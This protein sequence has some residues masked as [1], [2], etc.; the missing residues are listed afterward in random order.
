MQTLLQKNPDLSFAM[1][2]S[3]PMSSTYAGAAPLGPI[4][5]TARR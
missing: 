3:F 5:R 4:V 1:E 2:E